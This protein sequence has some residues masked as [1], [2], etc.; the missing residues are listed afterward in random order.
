VIV[1]GFLGGADALATEIARRAAAAG[2]GARIEMVGVTAPSPEGDARLIELAASNVG[3]ATVL[4]TSAPSL[5]AK[6]LDLALRYLPEVRCVALAQPPARLLETALAVADWAGATLVLVGPLEV[7]A[8]ATLDAWAAAGPIVLDPPGDSD[9]D[10]TFAGFVAAL[11]TRLD[12]GDP[13]EAA[14]RATVAELAVDP[15]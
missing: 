8:L 1:V 14:F 6:D 12:A 4:R 2:M 3:H 5:D 13:P 15:A 7:D 11:A 9:P 10:G